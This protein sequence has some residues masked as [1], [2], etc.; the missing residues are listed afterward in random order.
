MIKSKNKLNKTDIMNNILNQMK[1]NDS[2]K[3]KHYQEIK[4][5]K[6]INGYKEDNKRFEEKKKL[7]REIQKSR[8]MFYQGNGNGKKI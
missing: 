8:P 1:H 5:N 6:Q 3:K 7:Q 2:M 4:L